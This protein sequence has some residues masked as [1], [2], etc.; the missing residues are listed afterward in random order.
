MGEERALFP[1]CYLQGTVQLQRVGRIGARS[2]DEPEARLTRLRSQGQTS[3]AFRSAH[4]G[5]ELGAFC[6]NEPKDAMLVLILRPERGS[7]LRA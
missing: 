2:S 7:N 5:Y 6:R 1:A 4:A 3:P